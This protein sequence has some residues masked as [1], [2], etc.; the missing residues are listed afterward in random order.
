M[1]SLEERSL[2]Y[3]RVI[4]WQFKVDRLQILHDCNNQI[5]L[6]AATLVTGCQLSAAPNRD[7]CIFSA[8][9]KWPLV[10]TGKEKRKAK[11]YEALITM[12]SS[13]KVNVVLHRGHLIPSIYGIRVNA[14]KW[15]HSFAIII[16]CS[17]VWSIHFSPVEKV[18]RKTH[19]MG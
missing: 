4:L 13:H 9:N 8:A 5:L 19:S 14:K 17:P 16:S 11:W 3:A 1:L 10:F 12:P 2:F 18:W 15:K 7:W 6:Y